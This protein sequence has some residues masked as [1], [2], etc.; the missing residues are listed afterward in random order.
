MKY[1]VL[2][3]VNGNYSVHAEGITDVNSAK[4]TFHGLCQSLWNAPDVETACVM[5]AD[6]N[7]GVVQGYIENISHAESEEI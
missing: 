4:V 7:F 2:K 3:V 5:V 1:A 6:E